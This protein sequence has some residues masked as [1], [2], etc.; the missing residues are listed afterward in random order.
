MR[1]GF[2]KGVVD[3]CVDGLF[4]RVGFLR[5]LFSFSNYFVIYEYEWVM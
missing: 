4:R 1:R 5:A 3:G 2:E